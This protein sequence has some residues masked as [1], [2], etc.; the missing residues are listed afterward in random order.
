MLELRFD[1]GSGASVSCAGDTLNTSIYLKRMWP[2]GK[3]SY[4]T[5]LGVEAVSDRIM[6]F[7][8]AEC[9][10][11][12]HIVRLKSHNAGLYAISLDE[13]GERSFT[14]WRENSAARQM[15]S[16]TCGL[17]FSAL[18]EFDM[19][20]L[21]AIS[22]A[23][24]PENDRQR[25]YDFLA[26]YRASGGLVAF[27]SNYRPLLWHSRSVARKVI[28]Q[29]WQITDLALPSL[30]DEKALF[31]DTDEDAVVARLAEWGVNFGAL[32]RGSDGPRSLASDDLEGSFAPAEIV[33]DTTAAGDSFNAAFIATLI[34]G[35]S[36]RNCLLAGHKLACHVI[37]HTGAIVPTGEK[38]E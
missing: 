20:Y 30:D 27:D 22:L 23:I 17:D 24:L 13:T 15:F 9:I 38:N 19:I 10:D 14:Y 18:A 4:V 31:G 6:A 34:L 29:M 36:D 28:G 8:Q 12:S 37:E 5:A 1:N 25:L 26:V 32:K 3:I 35:G 2:Y 33:K 21:S 16:Q 7:I 11:T